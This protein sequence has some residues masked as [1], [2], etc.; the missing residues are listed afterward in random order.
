MGTS[1]RALTGAASG[2]GATIIL[3][4]L[5]EVLRRLGVI[6]KTAPMQIVDRLE[7]SALVK[8][9]SPAAQHASS[10]AAHLGYG[11]A[12]GAVFGVL[13]SERCEPATE[14]SV[15]VALGVLLWGVGWAGWL[16]ILGV[17]RAPWHQGTPRVALL[18]I[19]DHAAF[20][21][22]WGLLRRLLTREWR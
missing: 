8:D 19:A 9:L 7:E 22:A 11:T 20:G 21:A 13:R 18:P 14:L 2:F 4:G 3:S 17:Q 5:R 6:Y 16:P 10:L 15:G 1:E 12:A